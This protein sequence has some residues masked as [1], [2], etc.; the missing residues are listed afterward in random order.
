MRRRLPA[1]PRRFVSLLLPGVVALSLL[2]P[3]RTR[4][5]DFLR[6][7]DAAEAREIAVEA[8][9]YAY[10]A[11]MM[12]IT[13]RVLANAGDGTPEGFRGV[14]SNVLINRRDFPDDKFTAVVR[15]NV[16][17]L[18]SSMWLDLRQ[19][20]IVVDVGDSQGRYYLLQF[21]D[22]WTDTF[23]SPGKRTSGTGPQTYLLT[24][25]GWSGVVPSGVAELK[26][27]TA[28]AWMIG[29]AQ[30]NGPEDIPAVHRF[31]DGL[32][33]MPL[34]AWMQDKGRSYVP[35]K[36]TF[37]SQLDM[38]PPVEQVGAMG[39]E[40]FFSL[41][42]DVTRDN[43]PHLNDSPQLQ[44][45]E[46][47]GLVPG[48]PFS[49]SKLPPGVR[50]AFEQSPALAMARIKESRTLI[51]RTTNGWTSG[52]ASVGSYGTDYLKRAVIAYKGLGANVPEDAVYL[53]AFNQPDGRPFDSGAKYVWRLA[54][55]QKPPVRAFWSLTLYNDRQFFAANPIQRFAIG[56]RSPLV[57]NADGSLDIFIQ[58]ENPGP[59]REANWL[60]APESGSFSLS[61][62]LYWPE[63]EILRGEWQPPE[64]KRL[65]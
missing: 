23:A 56:D 38:T 18:Y 12:E 1:R 35:P 9:L 48:R 62:R 4:A 16:D 25:P 52:G 40:E 47:I 10:P 28:I 29:R 57:Y 50:Q 45:M 54:A 20:P 61:L 42:A 11:V 19:E 49:L 6:A 5:A 63:A 31:Q 43:P 21:M 44:R 17:T 24:A 37:D 26:S 58:R 39:A 3:S 27:P 65:P 32:R 7:A 46:R 13:R 60:P 8:Y 14:P 22:L 15:A 30:A 34:S 36:G 55:D 41:F 2:A 53:T 51:N 33:T 59:E 64:V